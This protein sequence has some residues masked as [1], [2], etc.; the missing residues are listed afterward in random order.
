MKRLNFSNRQYEMLLAVLGALLCFWIVRRYGATM[1]WVFMDEELYSRMSRLTP[2]ATADIANYLYF[3]TYRLTS[4]GGE[5]FLFWARMFNLAFL[6]GSVPFVYLTARQ[7]CPNPAAAL[8]A[9]LVL[10][11]PF[12]FHTV[13]FMPEAMYFFV[14]WVMTWVA[15]TRSAWHWAVHAATIGLVLGALMLTKVHGLFLVPAAVLYMVYLGW[16][17]RSLAIVVAGPLVLLSVAFAVKFGF[18][19]LVAGKKGLTLL[20]SFYEKQ[21]STSAESTPLLTL[22]PGA[23][24]SLKGHIMLLALVLAVP[25]AACVHGLAAR[26]RD[27]QQ[28]KLLVYSGLMFGAALGLTVFYTSSI[29]GYSPTE[30]LRLHSRY[31]S[32]TFPLLLI[33]ACA[34]LRQAD[35]HRPWLRWLFAATLA[36]L[37]VHASNALPKLFHVLIVDTAEMAM[38]GLNQPRSYAHVLLMIELAMLAL[39]AYRPRFGLYGAL[40]VV[41]PLLVWNGA[42]VTSQQIRD[43]R[44]GTV[45]DRGGQ[46][47]RQQVPPEERNSVAVIGTDMGSLQRTKFHIDAPDVQLTDVPWNWPVDP[48]SISGRKRWLLVLREHEMPAGMK[49]YAETAEFKLYRLGPNHVQLG[50]VDLSQPLDN[51]MLASVEGFAGPEQWGQWSKEDRVRLRFA[52][53]LPRRL[54]L[55]L[56]AQAFGPNVDKEF[57][58]RVGGE[59]RRFRMVGMPHEVF[60]TFDTDGTQ[61]EVVVE[62]PQAVSPKEL[63]ISGDERRLGMGVSKVGIGEGVTQIGSVAAEGAGKRRDLVAGSAQRAL[64]PGT[65]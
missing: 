51:T 54:N 2:L 4:T 20:G 1:P 17:R 6:A 11:S 18:S 10:L 25:V 58:I 31:Y 29:A 3:A 21:A 13:L 52:Q 43:A 48:A 9:L 38:L 39:W 41:M 36:A 8:I 16:E 44:I 32:F 42:V 14:F 35:G 12:H 55:Y 33:V 7:F 34:W 50:E 47:V 59:E 26:L 15:L 64:G 49:P 27:V 60:F 57:I 24:V 5:H 46:F 37:L 19:F 45:Y 28:R 63:G 56:K 61:R 53:P 62:V 40:G 30:G 23:L 22:I 65:E